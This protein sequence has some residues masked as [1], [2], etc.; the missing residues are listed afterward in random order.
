MVASDAALDELC[1]QLSNASVLG[2]D[3]E[4][5]RVR[6]YYPVLC[7]IQIYDGHQAV[8]VDT[9]NI[10]SLAPLF[11][12]FDESGLPILLHS[13]RQDFETFVVSAKRLPATVFD[14]QIAA[15]LT[16]PADQV[17]YAQLVKD[18]AGIELPKSQTRTNWARRPLSQ[19]QLFY[20]ADD[21][22]YLPALREHLQEQ[23]DKKNRLD[24]FHAE[25]ARL[26]TVGLYEP[27][28]DRAWRRCKSRRHFSDQ[29]RGAW[30]ALC[31]LR[32]ETACEQDKPRR[33][34]IEDAGIEEL[35]VLA[36]DDHDGIRAV[37]QSVKAHRGL[38]IEA[39]GERIA[40]ATPVTD[41]RPDRL[42]PAQMKTLDRGM[43]VVRKVAADLDI[44]PSVLAPRK[45]VEKLVRGERD[46][47][48]VS[49]WRRAVVGEPLLDVI[50]G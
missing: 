31:A 33:W 32:E 28:I 7:L 49:G 21:V 42:S 22:R 5:M 34:I 46:V 39:I 2:V 16:G 24:W 1:G 25:C 45:E 11:D 9:L 17:S 40:Q 43:Q 13:A 30:R 18:I 36:A 4:F 29:E 41:D 37:L 8:C 35:A 19:Q 15:A 14:T 12:C 6:T 27:D 38:Q 26:L 23:L 3:T 20:A 47:T 44:A 50:D 48:A 10:S